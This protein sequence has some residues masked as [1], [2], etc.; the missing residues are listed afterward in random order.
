MTVF[1]TFPFLNIMSTTLHPI[2]FQ[3]VKHVPMI[4]FGRQAAASVVPVAST[5]TSAAPPGSAG[6]EPIARI[7]HTSDMPSKYRRLPIDEEE[8]AYITVRH[9]SLSLSKPVEHT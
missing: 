3:M 1:V 5:Q 6:H 2:V 9:Q 8:A 7:T 4:K